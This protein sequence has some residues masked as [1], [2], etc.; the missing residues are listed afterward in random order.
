[1]KKLILIIVILCFFPVFSEAQ[2]AWEY[3][4]TKKLDVDPNGGQ[5]YFLSNSK[6]IT[7]NNGSIYFMGS[8]AL[9]ILNSD[10]SWSRLD[11]QNTPL[12]NNS[13]IIRDLAIGND[14]MCVSTNQGLL[15]I[16]DKDTLLLTEND[17]LGNSSM[18]SS[19]LYSVTIDKDKNP[20][21]LYRTFAKFAKFDGSKFEHYIA[22]S[23]KYYPLKGLTR[24]K[25]NNLWYRGFK[26][27]VKFDGT[28][29]KFWDST[30][31]P[32]RPDN[33]G[34]KFST[35]YHNKERNQ[36][37]L[38]TSPTGMPDDTDGQGVFWR[39]DIK[40]QTW[41]EIN[42]DIMS[43]EEQD[44]VYLM[45]TMDSKGNIYVG[46][47]KTLDKIF[48]LS[49]EGE[50]SIITIPFVELVGIDFVPLRSL[51]VDSKNNLWIG[52]L[53][54]G[55]IKANLD[56]LSSNTEEVEFSALPDI[57][58]RSVKPNPI[59]NNSRLELFIEP[60]FLDGLEIKIYDYLGIEV[61]DITS[62]LKYDTPSATGIIDFSLDENISSGVY[63][64]N[65]RSKTES[66]TILIMKE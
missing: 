57:W 28:N 39:F 26:T 2:D 16:S 35:F 24:D 49:P 55:V 3:Y 52:T 43:I 63:I 33:I 12:S 23:S 62:G 17:T 15:I 51:F 32:L 6:I 48:V 27:L 64:M 53:Q 1:M 25:D 37:L 42:L 45:T 8:A 11:Y 5:G 10:G 19:D 13:F 46:L 44:F 30:N 66:R 29:F 4:P 47:T 36:F 54:N 20:W 31:S 60:S 14:K 18:L 58:I 38:C 41:T 21:F 9:D 56:I 7:E 40:E 65:A 34:F 61:K 22:P 50:W 59:S